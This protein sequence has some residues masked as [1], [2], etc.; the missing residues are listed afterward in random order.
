MSKVTTISFM[1]PEMGMYFRKD[2]LRIPVPKM[3]DDC[4]VLMDMY[5]KYLKKFHRR[6]RHHPNQW[7]NLVK[8]QIDFLEIYEQAKTKEEDPETKKK[9][10]T[11][12]PFYRFK[13]PHRYNQGLY[14]ALKF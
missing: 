7:K 5:T 10:H 2:F 4:S 12:G 1:P 3:C 14:H 11:S 9:A 6:G 8:L 13:I